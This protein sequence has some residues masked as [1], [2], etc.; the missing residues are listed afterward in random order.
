VLSSW[1]TRAARTYCIGGS[2][3][4]VTEEVCTVPGSTTAAVR[5]S[6]EKTACEFLLAQDGGISDRTWC[7]VLT[8]TEDHWAEVLGRSRLMKRGV[9]GGG[10]IGEG[11]ATVGRGCRRVWHEWWSRN[12]RIALE[13]ERRSVQSEAGQTS[14]KTHLDD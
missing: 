12:R 7:R 5:P 4:L 6:W 13:R 8:L 2:K 10:A 1:T 9:N 14:L 11:E 3:D